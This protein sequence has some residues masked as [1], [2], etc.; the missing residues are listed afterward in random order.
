MSGR[1]AVGEHGAI[2]LTGSA[3]RG[4]VARTRTRDTD[5]AIRAR[6]A[7]GRTKAAATAA[8]RRQLSAPPATAGERLTGDSTIEDLAA[9]WLEELRLRDEVGAETYDFY[10]RGL[11]TLIVPALGGHRVSELRP[12][13]IKQ[14]YHRILT[15]VGPHDERSRTPARPLWAHK[16]LTQ[17]LRYAVEVGAIDHNPVNDLQP[18]RRGH[19][20]VG[21]VLTRE[22]FHEVVAAVSAY[23]RRPERGPRRS[24]R[25][26]D[27]VLLLAATG[28]RVGEVLALRWCDVNIGDGSTTVTISGTLLPAR[29]GLPLRRKDG[30][31]SEAGLRTITI[32][33]F[34]AEILRRLNDERTT[35]DPNAPVLTNRNGTWLSPSNIRREWRACRAGHDWDWV[36]PHTFRR[37]VAT[38]IDDHYTNPATGGTEGAGAPVAAAVLGHSSET[39]TRTYYIKKMRRTPDVSAILQH[40]LAHPAESAAS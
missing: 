8:L 32:P 18:P 28:G 15:P 3:D 25:L 5:G 9:A 12:V 40:T 20:A 7:T 10:R 21:S 31:K 29:D 38:F 4:W 11:K 13:T 6:Q 23:D 14:F 34:A 2:T 27:V 24:Y 33:D 30:T 19:N 22:L 17:M 1:L 36:T 39:I 35:D 16:V 26:L 37:T